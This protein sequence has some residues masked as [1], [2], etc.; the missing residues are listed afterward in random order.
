MPALPSVC[1]DGRLNGPG[2]TEPSAR[3]LCAEVPFSVRLE[4]LGNVWD[5]VFVYLLRANLVGP[6]FEPTRDLSSEVE[7]SRRRAVL[8]IVRWQSLASWNEHHASL[9]G[10]VQ[11]LLERIHRPALRELC[12]QVCLCELFQV[13]FFQAYLKFNAAMRLCNAGWKPAC[14]L[15]VR[16]PSC[17]Q[18]ACVG[19]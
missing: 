12:P 15:E 11:F 16:G 14:G 8:L 3:Q 18:D 17:R 4:L 2:E 7:V 1:G 19:P 5:Q 13:S 6:S 9:P 10:Y